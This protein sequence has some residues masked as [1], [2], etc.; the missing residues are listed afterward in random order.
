MSTQETKLKAIADAIREKDGTTAP[1][2]ANDF[3]E[4][5]RAISSVPDG[6]RTITLTAD[7][8]EGGTVS[9]GG[10][11]SDG[12]TV[13]VKAEA[14]KGYDS[15]GW[16]ENEQT[17]SKDPEYTFPANADRNL[18]ALF[19]ELPDFEWG[20]ENAVGDVNWWAGLKAWVAS[21]TEEERLA[22]VGKK[23]KTSIS[24]SFLGVNSGSSISMICIGADI[25]G[26]NTLTFH[27]EGI[28]PTF[29]YF[30]DSANYTTSIAKTNCDTF[31]NICSASNAIKEVTKLYC[32]VSNNKYDNEANERVKCRAWLPSQCEMGYTTTSKASS[33]QE[34][35]DGV[36][37]KAYSYYNSNN[38]RIKKKMNASGLITTSTGGYWNRSLSSASDTNVCYVDSSGAPYIAYYTGTYGSWGFTAAFVI[39]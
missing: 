38:K 34:W 13:T 15:A 6:L 21:V 11:V 8:P 35:T 9:G 16:Q 23:K 29:I 26:P 14:A 1:I 5:I 28:F 24:Q 33:Q 36:A 31:A 18:T 2:P 25:D 19:A 17:V 22:C 20:D 30:G 10:V 7:P 32:S 39:G 12:M 3:P 37:G 27:T 4:R